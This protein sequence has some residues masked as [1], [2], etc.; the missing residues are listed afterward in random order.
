MQIIKLMSKQTTILKSIQM[1]MNAPVKKN[2][3]KLWQV[4]ILLALAF[5][6]SPSLTAQVGCPLTCNDKLNIPLDEA[7]ERLL[8]PQDVL[9]NPGL[10]C[11]TYVLTLTYPFG[12]NTFNVPLVDRTHLGYTFIYKVTESTTRNSCW[13][14]L[15]IEDKFPPQPTCKSIDISCFQMAQYSA[16][17]GIVQDNCAQEGHAVI[18]NLVWT[19]YGCDSTI[20]GRVYR[21]IRSYDQWGNSSECMD[22]LR[23][24]K[25]SLELV[26]Q[27]D[28]ISLN[29]RVVCRKVGAT[30]SITNIANYDVIKF[31]SIMTD[32]TYP[33]P[34]LLLKLQARDTFGSSIRGC[35]SRDSLLVPALRDTILIAVAKNTPFPPRSGLTG[36]ALNDTCVRVDSCV[37]M[38]TTSG[39]LK[40]GLCKVSIT[41]KDEITSICGNGFKIRREWR[42]A[43]WCT[44]RDTILVQYIKVEDKENPVV[45]GGLKN[46]NANVKPHDCIAPVNINALTIDDCDALISQEYFISYSLGPKGKIVVLNGKL[47]GIVNLTALEGVFGR[48]CYKMYVDISDRCFNRTRDSI[49]ICVSDVNPPTP[50]CDENSQVIVDPATCWSRIYAQDLDNGSRDNCCELLHFAIAKMQDVTDAKNAAIAKIEKNCGKKEYWDKKTFYDA[51]IE[52][53][54]N[55]YIF[56]DYLDLTECGNQQIILRVYEACGIPLYDSHVFPCSYH[57]WFCYNTSHLFRAEFNFNSLDKRDVWYVGTKT[58]DCSWK[59]RILCGDSLTNWFNY[60]RTKNYDS[61]ENFPGSINFPSFGEFNQIFELSKNCFDLSYSA[62]FNTRTANL[63]ATEPGNTCSKYLYNDCMIM[64]NVVDKTP[65]ACDRAKDLTV[66]CD[67]IVGGESYNYAHYWE[68]TDGRKDGVWPNAIECVKEGDGILKDAFDPTGKPIGY[69]GGPLLIDSHDDHGFEPAPCDEKENSWKPIYCKEWLCLDTF[70]QG[71]KADYKSYFY[72]AMAAGGG[73]PTTS[74]GAG[75]FWIW[76]NCALSGEIPFVDDVQIDKCGKGWIKRTWTA[77]DKCGNTLICDQKIIAAHRSDF[78]VIFPADATVNCKDFTDINKLNPSDTGLTGNVMVMDDECELVGVNYEDTRYDVVEEGC[79][80]IIRKWTMIDWCKYDPIQHDRHPDIIVNDTLVADIHRRACVVRHLKDDGDGYIQYIQVIKVI[81]EVNPVL[82]CKDTT[83]C[84]FVENCTE[85]FTMNFTATDNC[86]P[87]SQIA[88]RWELDFKGDGTVEKRSV[89]NVKGISEVLTKGLYNITVYAT[90]RCGNEDTCTFKITI[91]DCKKPTPYCLNG[92]ATVL[93]PTTGKLVIW[94]SDFNAGSY[95]N[96]SIKDSLR[97]YFGDSA[98]VQPTTPSKTF[99]CSNLGIQELCIYVVDEAGNTDFCKTYVLIQDNGTPRICPQPN[100]I[101][102]GGAIRTETSEPVQGVK[103]ELR[104]GKESMDVKMTG[105]DGKFSFNVLDL[106]KTYEIHPDRNTDWMNGV[107]TRDLLAIQQHIMGI[108]PL[109]SMYKIIAAD[110]DNSKSINAVDLVELRKLI[111]GIYEELPHNKS[112]R[113][114]EKSSANPSAPFSYNEMVRNPGSFIAI[115]QNDFVGVK[116]GDVNQTVQAHQL[117]GTESRSSQYTIGLLVDNQA[118]KTGQRIEIPIKAESA[119]TLTGIQFTIGFDPSELEYSGF[120]N[121]AMTLEEANFGFH[122]L[123]KGLMPMS[124]IS[125]PAKNFKKEEVLFTLIFKAK[126]DGVVEDIMQIHSKITKAEAYASLG[127][128][129]IHSIRLVNRRH[130]GQALQGIKLYQNSPNPFSKNTLIG[131][132]LPIESKASLLII[133]I[134]GKIIKEIRGDFQKG[135]NEIKIQNTDLPSGGVYYY[136]MLTSNQKITKKLVLIE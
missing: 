75:K 118:F 63:I 35:I 65:P 116:I 79:Y 136:Q 97:F 33:S 128:A 20:L 86:T 92:I 124:W 106:S 131:F 135:Y 61:K 14:Y 127:D 29:C 15:F 53:W 114:V 107:S 134:A 42:V 101:A 2:E 80:K 87:A 19:E 25:D 95:D 51:Y 102:S 48:R 24:K 117:L 110:I 1:I 68:C 6:D 43:D 99:D 129:D 103:V 58:K 130:Q 82:N 100:L 62:N 3:F 70:D 96:C 120:K 122:Q 108:K 8:T 17:L 37:N 81:D 72:K 21:T 112:W 28:N 104:S 69:Y 77:I 44:G 125:T 90:D 57:D 32:A 23:I 109:N 41:Y 83:F 126:K 34:E 74:A 59:P 54:T 105:N 27:P 46:Y 88:Y 85:K 60:L 13:G 98:C 49:S 38:W 132:E 50:L 123:A 18:S 66:Y 133:D 56:K 26:K 39:V 47:P 16:I 73:R 30:G 94:A 22:T 67:G 121:N 45:S 5:L 64:V 91:K 11:G 12:T 55:C 115:P 40:G 4:P 36:L 78:E 111:L 93:M 52:N 9:E 113:F 84:T 76:D 7:C 119:M 10:M 71:K 89:P 31:S